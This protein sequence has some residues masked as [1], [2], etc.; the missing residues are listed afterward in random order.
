M[1]QRLNSTYGTRNLFNGNMYRDVSIDYAV[2][3]RDILH[4]SKAFEG[5][6]MMVVEV[7]KSQ[8][9]EEAVVDSEWMYN[10][11]D[12]GMVMDFNKILYSKFF[13]D[14]FQSPRGRGRADFLVIHPATGEPLN[15]ELR[16]SFT[17]ML[18]EMATPPEAQSYHH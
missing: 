6:P 18:T 10:I 3:V 13:E 7:L 14:D 17:R 4:Y 8:L 9:A 12:G 5:K 15:T 16:Q 11:E 2:R 1:L